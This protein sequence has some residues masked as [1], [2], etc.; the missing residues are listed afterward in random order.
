MLEPYGFFSIHKSHLVN[1]RQITRYLKNGVVEMSDGSEV[2]VSR[3]KREEFV[4][5]VVNGLKK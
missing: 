5:K 3:R 4:E 1:I 2:P